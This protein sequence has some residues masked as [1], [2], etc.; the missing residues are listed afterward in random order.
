M[1]LNMIPVLN[2][3]GVI[4]SQPKTISRF[5]AKEY[6]IAG[7]TNLEQSEADLIVDCVADAEIGRVI[8]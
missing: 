2:Y 4:L 8:F 7:K 6:G 1:P 5:L 3:D